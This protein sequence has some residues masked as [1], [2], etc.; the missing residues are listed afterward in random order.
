MEVYKL[1]E[2]EGENIV[3]VDVK[4]FRLSRDTTRRTNLE[5]RTAMSFESIEK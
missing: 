5:M 4:P 3:L 2:P 1:E